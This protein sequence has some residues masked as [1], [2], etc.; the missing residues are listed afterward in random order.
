MYSSKVKQ[1]IQHSLA[2]I[3]SLKVNQPHPIDPLEITRDTG[4]RG[5]AVCGRWLEGEHTDLLNEQTRLS[6]TSAPL[7]AST[8]L[9]A[10]MWSS[11]SNLAVWSQSAS[12]REAP[13]LLDPILLWLEDLLD[14]IWLRDLWLE[15][16]LEDPLENPLDLLQDPQEEVSVGVFVCWV[17]AAPS[18]SSHTVTVW[19]ELETYISCVGGER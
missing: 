4:T 8:W 9:K 7:T 18:W 16:P 2:Y 10:L 19:L 12:M 11:A 1:C 6:T 15:D 3:I 13:G 14:P 5:S 17:W